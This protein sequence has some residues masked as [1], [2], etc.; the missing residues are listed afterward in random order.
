MVRFNHS[1]EAAN[2]NVIVFG[3]TRPGFEHTIY[4]TRGNLANHYTTD[5]VAGQWKPS[6]GI[7][8]FSAKQVTLRSKCKDWFA[9]NQNNVSEWSDVSSRGSLFQWA[10]TIQIRL[11]V[12]FFFDLRILITSLLYLQTLLDM[13]VFIAIQIM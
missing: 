2:A 7:C 4:R 5:A 9:R 3:F 6:G 8:C 11:S 13:H 1:G 12:L 10:S